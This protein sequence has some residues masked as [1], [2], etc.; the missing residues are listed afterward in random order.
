M[1]DSAAKLELLLQAAETQQAL[2][3]TA[4]ERL[5]DYTACLD[6]TVRD[7]IRATLIEELRSLGE[8][9]RRAENTL[10]GV[11]RAAN[12]R[13]LLWSVT[14][15]A[16]AA[17]V[18]LALAWPLLPSPAEVASLRSAR[19]ALRAQVEQLAQQG[20]H[21]QLSHCGSSHRL[22]VRVDRHAGT[23]GAAGDYLV[24]QGY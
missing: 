16:V 5:R 18:P 19:E 6:A 24:V 14:S 10:R 8:D 4:L 22:C 17:A 3:G 23:Y 15:A 12:L 7:E 9:A 20:G 21:V 1:E 2:A 13:L 11:A